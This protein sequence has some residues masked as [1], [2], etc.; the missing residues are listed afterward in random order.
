MILLETHPQ[1]TELRSLISSVSGFPIS[2][3]RLQDLAIKRRFSVDVVNFYKLFP[4]EQQFSS[5]GDLEARTEMLELL[6]T[7]S[8]PPEDVVH[9]AED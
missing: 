6:Q 5:R 7:E 8:Q 4:G 9:G 3:S 1:L 2:A